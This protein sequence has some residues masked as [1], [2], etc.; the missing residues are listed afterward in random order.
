MTSEKSATYHRLIT[1]AA[2]CF[3]EK[4]FNA[5]SVSDIARRAAVS[6]GAMYTYFKGKG[7]LITA[8]VMEEQHTALQNYTLSYQCSP[9]ER[10]CQLM[11]SCINEVG[12]PAD[13]RLWVEIIAESSRNQTVRETFILTDKIMRDG[14]KSIISAGIARGDFAGDLDLEASTIALFALIDGLIARKAINTDFNLERDMPGFN[15]LVEKILV[16]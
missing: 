7:E 6:Q 10:I 4:G 9:F 11:K 12:Y 5:T 14:I 1:A 3:S 2:A 15:R 13:H 8:I 16:V